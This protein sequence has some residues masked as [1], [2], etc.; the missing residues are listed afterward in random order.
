MLTNCF[1]SIIVPMTSIRTS[2]DREEFDR[3]LLELSDLLD[4]DEDL[5]EIFDFVLARD[6]GEF[7]EAENS[8]FPKS[9]LVKVSSSFKR[10]KTLS[11]ASR[12]GSSSVSSVTTSAFSISFRPLD[13]RL[14]EGIF[15]MEALLEDNPE[16]IF[17]D[18]NVV[19]LLDLLT[20]VI[21]VS[22]VLGG[23]VLFEASSSTSLDLLRP[24]DLFVV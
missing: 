13:L 12:R 4:E 7:D 9:S 8:L 23:P 21:R 15:E 22:A 1:C 2:F 19:S 3:R 24:K 20:S 5:T 18:A 11:S 6:L 14:L 10:A 17:F 16:F